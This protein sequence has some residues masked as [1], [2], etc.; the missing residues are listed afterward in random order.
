MANSKSQ[1]C[2]GLMPL[3]LRRPTGPR[4]CFCTIR[5]S[6]GHLAH[7]SPKSG[8]RGRTCARRRRHPRV[9]LIATGHVHRATLSMFAGVPTTICPAPNNAVDLDLAK[10]RQPSFKVEPPAFHLHTWFPGEGFGTVVTHHVPIGRF[11]GPHPFFRS[12]WEA[13]LGRHPNALSNDCQPEPIERNLS[14]K[15]AAADVPQAIACPLMEETECAM[16][17]SL[18]LP[19]LA[20]LFKSRKLLCAAKL[21][22]PADQDDRAAGSGECG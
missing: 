9:R 17:R 1:R 10:L 3:W 19:G 2:N 7:G 14:R 8:Q 21:S 18:V 16:L 22:G 15:I 11:D 4:C 13:A 6:S 20:L 5:R 12:G